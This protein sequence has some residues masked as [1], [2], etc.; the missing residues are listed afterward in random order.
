MTRFFLPRVRPAPPPLPGAAGP[1][2][3]HAPWAPF[4]V[5]ATVA[6][7]AA[8][9][10]CFNPAQFGD[11][12]EQF[13]WSHSLEW[14]YA[15]HPP[16]PT[17]LLGAAIAVFG[18]APWL[19]FAAGAACFAA[20]GAFTWAI[21]RR[22]L[23]ERA[24]LVAMLLW[25]LQTSFS[26]RAQLYNHN[27]A[28]VL[29]IAAAVWC[30]L[31]ALDR[32]PGGWAWWLG[33]GVAAGCAMLSKYQALLPLAGVLLALGWTGRLRERRTL[34]GVA[35]A[36]AMMS[37]VF[38][39]HAAWVAGHDFTTLRYAATSMQDATPANALRAALS[40]VANQLRM[41][42]AVF[43]AL[44]VCAA[45]AFAARRR[46]ATRRV[47]D[48]PGVPSSPDTGRWLFALVWAPALALL[49]SSAFGVGLRNHW[50]V[51]TFQFVSLWIA[52]RWQRR[53]GAVDLTR[54]AR[55]VLAL[56][57]TMLA[58]YAVQQR[59]PRA[60]DG[61]RRL[62]TLYPAHALAQ[63]ATAEWRAA[64]ACPLR[65]V[66]GDSFL[67][68]L[69]ALYAGEGAVVY[70]D[71]ASTPWVDPATLARAGFVVLAERREDLPAGVSRQA[72]FTLRAPGAAAG[73]RTV[74]FGIVA[75]RAACR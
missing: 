23:G 30:C 25:S 2:T 50:G 48:A 26:W 46:G 29:F 10:A 55:V 75:P 20:T 67:A 52:W 33:A 72:T 53:G 42:V 12:I 14:G 36:V 51:Q 73:G 71:A 41:L 66:A 44:A 38:A 19:G 69:A 28:L 15:K 24:A 63:A 34:W 5:A 57:L 62:D 8:W 18:R 31:R 70:G 54:L 40:F 45:L 13:N 17:W 47:A 3:A 35:L 65:F 60:L 59:Q 74:F 6:L 49:A 1:A 4:A 7:W 37:A 21:A 43:V 39:P 9:A 58:L 32:R 64:T 68:G 27:T 16:L 56:H 61:A 11:N 22:L